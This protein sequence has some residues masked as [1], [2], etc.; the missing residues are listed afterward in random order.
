MLTE[1]R[2]KNFKRLGDVRIPLG[3]TVVFIGPNNAGKT[4]ALQALALWEAGLRAWVRRHGI[5]GARAAGKRPG[6]P[7]NR[8]DLVAAP[9]PSAL[10]LWNGLRV[11]RSRKDPGTDRQMTENVRIAVGVS[12]VSA[13]KGWS[14]GFEFD[15]ANEESFYCRPCGDGGPNLEE[16]AKVRASF[17]PPMSGLAEQEYIKQPG[18]IDVLIGQGQTAQVLRNLCLAAARDAGAW[19]RVA[20]AVRQMFG[21]TLHP[22]EVIPGRAEITM[23]YGDGR[24]MELDLTCAGRGF[25][26]TLLL[27]SY[28]YAN[29]GRVLLLDEPDA[30]LEILR[31]RQIFDVLCAAAEE[32]G[33]QVII[34]SHSEVVLNSASGKGDVVAFTGSRPHLLNGGKNKGRQLLKSLRDIGF[35]QYYLAEQCGWVIYLEDVTDLDILRGFARILGH[36]AA[37]DLER[38]FFH[39]LGT[40]VPQQA[41]DHFFGLK[42]AKEDLVGVALFDR[43]DKKL[44]DGGPLVETMWERREIENYFCTPGVLLA[45]AGSGLPDDLFG[46]AERDRRVAAM[47]RAIRSVSEA[48]ETLRG[49]SPWSADVKASDDFLDPLFKRF[50]ADLGIPPA[51]RKRG[52]HELV[53]H[54]ERGDVPEEVARKLDIIHEVAGRAR[55]PRGTDG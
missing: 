4:T 20:G 41:R 18:E 1:L 5:G 32:Q 10:F 14:C 26:Q 17:L 22:P 38:P 25:H 45:Y 48:Y 50:S 51:L 2:I 47:E 55:R 53:K 44:A 27:L 43:I 3:R 46:H 19:G 31:Q 11:R 8:R 28:L 21:V 33:S 29:P 6:V 37:E 16:A 49:A 13:G 9:V 52:Y 23:S 30:H 34:A 36:P 42:E 54:M 39:P 40:N 12:G 24:G 35:D 7:I 15:Y